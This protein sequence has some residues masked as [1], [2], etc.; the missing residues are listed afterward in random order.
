MKTLDPSSGS[1]VKPEMRLSSAHTFPAPCGQPHFRGGIH[2]RFGNGKGESTKWLRDVSDKLTARW[3]G[4]RTS[5]FFSHAAE[6]GPAVLRLCTKRKK[7]GAKSIEIP[8]GM[9]C[10][11]LWSQES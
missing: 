9:D 7:R 11:V 1:C 10:F 3:G 6:P 8:K 4:S 2:L 5:S